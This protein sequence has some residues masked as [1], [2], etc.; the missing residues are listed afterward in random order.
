ML[1]NP[2]LMFV[3]GLQMF[4]GHLFNATSTTSGGNV[5]FYL[6]DTGTAGGNAVFANVIT[7][8]VMLTAVSTTLPVSYGT[9]VVSGDKKTLTIPVYQPGTSQSVVTILGINVLSGTSLVPV[10]AANGIPVR[11]VVQGQLP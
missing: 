4:D 2:E 3:N 10:A 8:S 5:V 1:I 9:P 6:T 7:E 11:M